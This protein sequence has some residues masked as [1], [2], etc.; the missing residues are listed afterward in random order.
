M[1]KIL[2]TIAFAMLGATSLPLSANTENRISPL[3]TTDSGC[4]S[5]TRSDD[6]YS[7]DYDADAWDIDYTEGILSVT[8]VNFIANCCP[9]GFNS[10]FELEDENH[11]IYNL[12]GNEEF[13]DCLCVF[14]V[15]STFGEIAPGHYT[16]TFRSYFDIFTAEVDIEEG[17][18]IHL[19]KAPAGIHSL[20]AYDDMINLSADGVLHVLTQGKATVEIYAASGALRTR[21]N[22]TDA[23]DINITSLDKGIYIAK[24]TVGDSSSI[25]RFIR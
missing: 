5:N 3:S 1:K 13:C 21:I 25:L 14:D 4:H 19:E 23:A 8:W 20:S 7:E 10:W 17:N 18:K 24:L 9:E 12:K 11:L 2:L 15:T 22:V 16:I 6:P